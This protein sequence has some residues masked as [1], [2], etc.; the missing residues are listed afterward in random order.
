[1]K[2][3][4]QTG[5]V[6]LQINT[7]TIINNFSILFVNSN[8]SLTATSALSSQCHD[9][10]FYIL[11]WVTTDVL[12][13]DL[14]YA[15]FLYLFTDV[16]Y[17]FAEDFN[18]LDDVVDHLW[19]WAAAGSGTQMFACLRVIIVF[20]GDEASPTYNLLQEENLQFN[21]QH[22]AVLQFFFHISVLW[23]AD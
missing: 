12:V 6:N 2:K 11:C 23:M 21:L 22:E 19:A 13:F 5:F 9:I 20:H 15:Q 14:L 10:Q 16:I 7:S 8:P 4:Y 3:V 1:M 18:D 17:I